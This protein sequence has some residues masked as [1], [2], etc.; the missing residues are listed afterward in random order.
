[1]APVVLRP[2]ALGAETSELDEIPPALAL[3]E[4]LPYCPA[5]HSVQT[6]LLPDAA[7][8]PPTHARHAVAPLPLA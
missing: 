6:L 5:T 7:Y 2:Q 3:P 4:T 8:E 1:M